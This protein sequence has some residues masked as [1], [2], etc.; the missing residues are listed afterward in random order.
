MEEVE[1]FVPHLLPARGMRRLL[2][3]VGPRHVVKLSRLVLAVAST[4]FSEGDHTDVGNDGPH[5]ELHRHY[6]PMP[7]HFS[8]N[9]DKKLETIK[10]S[11]SLAAANGH[12]T[13]SPDEVVSF[14]F[15]AQ[16]IKRQ[17]TVVAQ[18]RD[19]QITKKKQLVNHFF[20]GPVMAEIDE[21]TTVKVPGQFV[22]ARNTCSLVQVVVPDNLAYSFVGRVF[23]ITFDTDCS[24]Y[25]CEMFGTLFEVP[26]TVD[27]SNDRSPY[28]FDK[29]SLEH[30][31]SRLQIIEAEKLRIAGLVLHGEELDEDEVRDDD[32]ETQEDQEEV[33]EDPDA[34]AEEGEE[35]E[36]AE[37]DEDG[38]DAA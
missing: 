32:E 35:E 33:E 15:E 2:V 12:D 4:R 19:V 1:Y 6:D 7:G 10:L 17:H 26:E 9:V 3:D 16:I 21:E 8:E 27:V 13:V 22:K 18:K 11:G 23:S 25:A 31:N 24:V 14:A 36:E 28:I 20:R 38:R 30:G 34:E 5:Q 29:L 37:A